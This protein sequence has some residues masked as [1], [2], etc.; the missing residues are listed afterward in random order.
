M[1]GS[2]SISKDK[3]SQNNRINIITVLL[4]ILP[5]IDTLNGI[6]PKIPIGKIY[7][8]SLGI[9]VFLYLCIKC[10]KIKKSYAL[11]LGCSALYILL[12]IA[13]NIFLGGTLLSIEYPLKL[14]F[15]MLLLVSLVQCTEYGL[16]CGN[17]FYYI[18]DVASWLFI[19][20]YLIP[21]I[22]GIGNRVYVGDIGYKG[23][24]IAQNELGLIVVVFCFFTAFQL[25]N[26]IKLL[27]VIKIACL[28]TC[29]LL[30]NTK[31]AIIAS[32]IAVVMWFV[33][34][35]IKGKTKYK[36]I[37]L[38]VVVIGIVVLKDT[39][40]NS[41]VLALQR[42]SML[43]TKYYGGSVATGLLSGRNNTVSAAWKYLNENYYI[44]RFLLGNG[45]CSE[46]LTEMD[47]IDI[48]FY[49]GL[50]GVTFIIAMLC[51]F[52]VVIIRNSKMDKSKIRV[53]SY[54][55][56][57]ALLFWAGH[58]LFMAMSGCY[59]VIYLCFLF[60]YKESMSKCS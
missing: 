15:N 7:K 17:D 23:F 48:F 30:L 45:F 4:C 27:S 5:L 26:R 31:T 37:T 43:T 52:L 1:S 12:S 11:I 8:M 14:V 2:I 3:C 49:L 40:I 36:I 56:V 53:V 58:V 6:Y 41:F 25:I 19:G 10:G 13:I 28:L 60:Y 38:S 18:L 32:L 59:F 20:C 51:Y 22:L 50:V 42:F 47:I 34:A 44:L 57:I 35:I 54:L 21:Y 55:V 46:L 16:F 9:L 33:P 29:G 39:I 24:F